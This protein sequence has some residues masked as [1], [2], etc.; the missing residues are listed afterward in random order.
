[1]DAAI[2][3]FYAAVQA[4]PN[5][6]AAIDW[7]TK[8][9]ISEKRYAEVFAL[10]KGA[11]PDE[12]LEMNLAIAYSKSGDNNQ[13]IRILSQMVKDRPS[14]AVA[15]SGLATVYTRQRRYQDAA[16]EFQ[17][18]LRL[19]PKDDAV[20]LSY[21]KSLIELADFKASLPILKDYLRRHPTEFEPHYL[22][23]VVDRELGDDAEAKEM[24]AQALRMNPNHYDVRYSLG[25]VLLRSGHPGEARK[26]LEEA[27]RLNPSSSEA[28]FQLAAAF[29]SLGLQEQ[30][31]QQLELYQRGLQERAKKD[32]AVTKSNQANEYL[33]QGDVQKALDLYKEAI[34]EDPKNPLLLYNLALA[35]DRQGDQ[36][37]EREALRQAIELDPG[38]AAA[39]NQI[40]Y[41][42]LQAGQTGEAEKEFKKAISLD[43][44]YAEA[45][46]NLGTLYGQG[47]NDAAAEQL[48]RE[49]IK[50]DPA[51]TQALVNLGATLASE[52]NFA[53]ADAALQEALRIEPGNKEARELR[54]MIMTKTQGNEIPKVAK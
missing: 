46:N 4:D 40:G 3:E 36:H 21:A 39:H 19:N 27:L 15:H 50:S 1:M 47:G 53:E 7:L 23:G 10:L 26:Q 42:I 6:V 8:S 17:E 43:S 45:Q 38:F 49:A 25:F 18:A 33:A 29:R 12:G 28:H 11:P 34:A 35:L 31:R 24:L 44:H 14:S 13:A 16:N 48:F 9:L 22:I 32:V 2:D 37:G 41:L 30:A 20:R 52:S 51:Y 5:G 54:A